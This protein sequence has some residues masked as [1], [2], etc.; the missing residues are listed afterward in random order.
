[1]KQ[2]IICDSFLKDQQELYK[3]NHYL[4]SSQCQIYYVQAYNW[5]TSEIDINVVNEIR[6]EVFGIDRLMQ[7]EIDR[8]IDK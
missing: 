3:N 5:N 1:M 2:C 7:Y 4:C 6:K 8:R